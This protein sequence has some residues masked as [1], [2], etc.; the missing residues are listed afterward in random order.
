MAVIAAGD[1]AAA[2]ERVGSEPW[3]GEALATVLRRTER[4]LAAPAAVPSQAG[5]WLHDYACPRHWG[6]LLF[7][8]ASPSRHR[9]PAGEDVEG[10][11]P[12]GG[13]V[14]LRHRRLAELARDLALVGALTGDGRSTAG[15]ASILLD[16][17]RRYPGYDGGANARPGMIRGRAFQQALTEAL[18]AVPLAHAFDLAAPSMARADRDQVARELLRPVAE[19]LTAAR[20]SLEARADGLAHNYNAWFMAGLG[21][22]GFALGDDAVVASALDA[23]AGFAGQLD[24]SFLPDGW[25]WEV[26]PYY[27][28]FVALA[29]TLLAEAAAASGVDLYRARGAAGQSIELAWR[30]FAGLAAAWGGPPDRNDGAYWAGGP[31]E[32]EIVELYEVAQARRPEPAFAW[33]VDQAA[34]G[35]RAGRDRWSSLVHGREDVSGAARPARSTVMFPAAGFAVMGPDP[36]A[37]IVFG[38]PGGAHEHRDK[39][40]LGLRGWATDPGMTPYGVPAGRD[41]YRSTAA[42]NTVVV[43]GGDQAPRAGELL[44]WRPEGGAWRLLA[45]VEGAHP[46]IVMTRELRHDGGALRDTVEM[47]SDAEHTYDWLLHLDGEV[48]VEPMPEPAEGPLGATGAYR[49]LRLLGRVRSGRIDAWVSGPGGELRLRLDGAGTELEVMVLSAPGTSAAPE[50]RRTCL[51]AR[52]RARVATFRACFLVAEAPHPSREKV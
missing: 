50:R 21:C 51:L 7:D 52:R 13:W 35:R 41:W 39:L 11:R 24:R 18:W 25:E 34:G 46:G 32:A 36:A 15:A 38:R 16:Y 48:A 2:R 1:L 20:R 44:D 14:V 47:R 17:A 28:C 40:S 8:P 27:H 22:I 12:D 45:R 30:A 26:T 6:A 29:L 4:W 5:G 43:D 3:A 42:H 33:L 10:A 19:A 9:C 37:M 49:E 31:F 23:P